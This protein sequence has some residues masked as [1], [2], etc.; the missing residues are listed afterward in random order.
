MG[1]HI[2]ESKFDQAERKAFVQH[3]LDDIKALEVLLD[4]NLIES[5]VVRIGAEQENV[6]GK[7]RF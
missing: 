3:L 5:D 4:Q 7:S 6:L 1:E 2:S